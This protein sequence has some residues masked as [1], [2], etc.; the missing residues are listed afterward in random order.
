MEWIWNWDLYS[1]VMNLKLWVSRLMVKVK[2]WLW[3][4]KAPI[5]CEGKAASVFGKT[6]HCPNRQKSHL[7]WT[8]SIKSC[9]KISRRVQINLFSVHFFYTLVFPYSLWFGILSFV[10]VYVYLLESNRNFV[11][12]ILFYGL[13][14]FIFSFIFIHKYHMT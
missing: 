4:D 3:I 6:V 10:F 14:A 2:Q 12:R 11:W 7:N 13:R 1:L 5:V 8:L 9:Q